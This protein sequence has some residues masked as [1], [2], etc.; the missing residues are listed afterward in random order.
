MGFLFGLLCLLSFSFGQRVSA[1]AVRN[2]SAVRI[3]NTQQQ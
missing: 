2:A 1:T 3:P